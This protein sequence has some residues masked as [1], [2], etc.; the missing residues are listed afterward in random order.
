[1]A[2]ATEAAVQEAL[3]T[4]RANNAAIATANAEAVVAGHDGSPNLSGGGDGEDRRREEQ[5][6]ARPP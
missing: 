1:M 2:A 3:E 5:A 4:V 6:R